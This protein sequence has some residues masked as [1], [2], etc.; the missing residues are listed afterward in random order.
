[1][2]GGEGVG[3][4]RWAGEGKHVRRSTLKVKNICAEIF[5]F[6]EPC[7]SGRQEYESK[8]CNNDKLV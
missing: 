7:C 2:V 1:M 5:A 6:S 8:I 3:G 4:G